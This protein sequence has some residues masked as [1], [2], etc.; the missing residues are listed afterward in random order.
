MPLAAVLAI[1]SLSSVWPARAEATDPTVSQS[2]APSA[3]AAPTASTPARPTS[4]PVALPGL[5]PGPIAALIPVSLPLDQVVDRLGP[6]TT[7]A[8]NPDTSTATS[9]AASS[10]TT[11]AANLAPTD[12]TAA[13]P[14]ADASI[15]AAAPSPV[16]N[17]AS[18]TARLAATIHEHRQGNRL[19]ATVYVRNIPVL[20]LVDPEPSAKSLASADRPSARVRARQIVSQLEA[21]AARQ[22]DSSQIRYEWS[23]RDQKYWISAAGEPLVAVDQ[24]VTAPQ[25]SNSYSSD[26]LEIT[27]LLRRQL[28][29]AAPLPRAIGPNR[30]RDGSSALALNP[31][32]NRDGNGSVAPAGY[33]VRSTQE[34]QASWYGGSF[35]G[36]PTAN[37]ERFNQNALTAAHKTLPF[38]TRV[39]VINPRTGQSVIVRINDRGPFVRGRIIDLSVAAARAID[40]YDSGI[41]QVRLEIL[42]PATTL[43]AAR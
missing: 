23:D 28:G 16:A 39:R 34:G 15:E 9:P 36:Q 26:A 22:V 2:A 40:T 30:F 1:A 27:N 29:N 37:G 3:T 20:S 19:V 43:E 18:T 12:P 8:A 11:P 7:T 33:V 38:G 6:A 14:A 31:G 17:Q 5:L 24:L 4:V 32:L 21:L 41:A 25:A 13:R 42:A 35:H 10:A